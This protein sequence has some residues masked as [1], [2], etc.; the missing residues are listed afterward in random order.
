MPTI[1]ARRDYNELLPRLVTSQT[2]KFTL[3]P[4]PGT[5][6][7]GGEARAAQ[8]IDFLIAITITDATIM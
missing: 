5:C 2:L 1:T 7:K 8:L 4:P 6:N 3:T